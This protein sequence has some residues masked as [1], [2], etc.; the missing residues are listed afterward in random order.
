MS[1]ACPGNRS[2]Y[3][4]TEGRSP[5]PLRRS[6]SKSS[7][8][9]SIAGRSGSGAALRNASIL[10]RPPAC[11]AASNRSQIRS[12]RS[13]IVGGRSRPQ[14]T[15]S[16]LMAT[17][18]AATPCGS[19]GASAPRSAGCIPSARRSARCVPLHAARAIRR[20]ASSRR[21]A[22][23]W[24]HSSATIAANSGVG[25]SLASWSSPI[26]APGSARRVPPHR[27]PG[28]RRAVAGARALVWSRTLRP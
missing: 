24:R 15:R 27:R 6:S 23:L 12:T 3:S 21:P 2:R 14:R 8:S 26:P 22:S 7:S 28:R 4:C 1:S 13:A 10:A 25:P 17:P 11:Q 9:R 5:P 18:P 19:G 20:S 16:P